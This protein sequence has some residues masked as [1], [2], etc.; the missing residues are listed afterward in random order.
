M[1]WAM[2]CN[3]RGHY[4]KNTRRR[5][6]ANKRLSEEWGEVKE[7]LVRRFATQGYIPEM[8]EVII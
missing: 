4:R 5:N 2:T 6:I 8:K 7:G 1:T 3:T